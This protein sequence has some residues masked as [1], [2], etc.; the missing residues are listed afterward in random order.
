MKIK[1]IIAFGS[2]A[3]VMMTASCSS[4]QNEPATEAAN[5]ALQVSVDGIEGTRAVIDSEYLPSGSDFSLWA[6]SK[7]SEKTIE[8]GDNALVH[9]NGYEAVLKEPVYIPAKDTVGV[10]AIYP[11]IGEYDYYVKLDLTKGEDYLWGEGLNY[12]TALNPKVSIRFRHLLSRITLHF[13]VSSDNEAS[14]DFKSVNLNGDGFGTWR[15]VWVLPTT[16]K[17]DEQTFLEYQPIPGHMSSDALYKG[18]DLT[19]TFL[20]APTPEWADQKTNWMVQLNS[21]ML[22]DSFLIPGAFYHAGINCV[23]NVQV[24]DGDKLVVTDCEIQPW[25]NN[26][27]PDI[28]ISE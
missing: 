25:E 13:T 10:S 5:L 18:H 23:Y 20:V 4:E 6:W 27:M 26:E 19:V 14:Y 24:S 8:G 3:A 28:N 7:D 17:I 9:M 1:S 11:Y 12:A 21:S 16:G 2:M 15:E 22:I